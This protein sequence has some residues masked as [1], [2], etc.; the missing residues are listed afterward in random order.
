MFNQ[1]HGK[2]DRLDIEVDPPFA[3][4]Q[5]SDEISEDIAIDKVQNPDHYRQGASPYDMAKSIYGSEAL[6]RLIT[7]NF[8]KYANYYPR[9]YKVVRDGQMGD[10]VKASQAFDTAVELHE[11]ICG[12][13]IVRCG[14]E[15]E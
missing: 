3:F 8:V 6:L 9:D 5:S 1:I 2:D 4:E 10:L 15:M 11:E 14:G 12:T 7:L 13:D